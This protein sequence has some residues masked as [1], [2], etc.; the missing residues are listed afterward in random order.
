MQQHIEADFVKPL[1]AH[2]QDTSR[3]SRMRRP[4]QERRV[5]MTQTTTSKDQA[6]RAF[7]SFA[8]DAKFAGGDWREND[9]TGCVY[10]EK[11]DMFVKVGDSFRPASFFLGGGANDPV[12]GVCVVPAPKT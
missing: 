7:L 3:F 11:G 2:D 5:R 12:A 4:P 1:D 9:I 8:I 6:G 10:S